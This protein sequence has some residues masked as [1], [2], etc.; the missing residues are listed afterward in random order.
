MRPDGLN[1]CPGALSC[2]ALFTLDYKSSFHHPSF[3][4][5]AAIFICSQAVSACRHITSLH[6]IVARFFTAIF[7]HFGLDVYAFIR[8]GRHEHV[9]LLTQYDFSSEGS[10]KRMDTGCILQRTK[11]NFHN[12]ACN[13]NRSFKAL[14]LIWIFYKS[15]CRTLTTVLLYPY[16]V[17]LE[18]ARS[19][20]MRPRRA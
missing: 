10:L 5:C 20:R 1:T 11:R 13:I 8:A 2:G 14:S 12:T 16:S 19:I 7:R 4:L 3:F 18:V 9:H 6:A 17:I 15:W